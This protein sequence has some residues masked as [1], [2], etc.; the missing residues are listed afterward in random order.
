MK[1]ETTYTSPFSG[2]TFKVL[3]ETDWRQAWDAEGNAYK[4]WYNTYSFFYQGDK[5]LTTLSLDENHLKATFGE[6]EGVYKA[7]TTSRYD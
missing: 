2:K 5:V 3:T 7:W 4:N 1:N 6:L